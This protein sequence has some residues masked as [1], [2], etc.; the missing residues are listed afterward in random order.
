MHQIPANPGHFPRRCDPECHTTPLFLHWRCR[1]FW[2][3]D[4]GSYWLL[5]RQKHTPYPARYFC[6]SL[7]INKLPKYTLR[8]GTSESTQRQLRFCNLLII[9]RPKTERWLW[10]GK[11]AGKLLFRSRRLEC[12]EKSAGKIKFSFLCY[13]ARQSFVWTL[14]G[15]CFPGRSE[16]ESLE[17]VKFC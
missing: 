10:G 8:L 9:K 3:E 16:N 15:H 6:K 13:L 7:I 14:L 1:S 4:T 12:G 5:G 2:R 11:Y 17:R